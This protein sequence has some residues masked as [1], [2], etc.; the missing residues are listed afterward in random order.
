MK[1]CNSQVPVNNLCV[2]NMPAIKSYFS[3]L[4]AV[5]LYL[6]LPLLFAGSEHIQAQQITFNKTFGNSAYNQGV[7]TFQ[8]ADSGYVVVGNSA[9]FAGTTA[10]YL[11]WID[12]QGNLL[13]DRMISRPFLLKVNGA[14]MHDSL[15]YLTGFAYNQG[16]YDFM[17]LKIDLA[18]N[19]LLEKYWGT[20][21]W[22]FANDLVVDNSKQIYLAGESTDTVYGEMNGVVICLDSN[23]VLIWEKS[24]GGPGY[25]A[26]FAID[27]GFGQTLVMAG[28]SAGVSTPG[29]SAFYLASTDL[30][31]N[32]LWERVLNAPGTNVAYDIQPDIQGGYILCG[33]TSSPSSVLGQ[34]ALLFKTDTTGNLLWQTPFGMQ[35]NDA[36]HAVLQLPDST[37]RMAGY[38]AGEFSYGMNDFYFQNATKFGNWGGQAAGYIT[39]GGTKDDWAVH[40][41]RTL[42]GGFLLTGTTN[43]F[44]YGLSNIFLLKLGDSAQFSPYGGHQTAMS[45]P[46]HHIMKRFEVYPNPAK[47]DLLITGRGTGNSPL[48]CYLVDIQ[49]RVVK[50]FDPNLFTE[51]SVKLQ[52]GDLPEGI[53]FLKIGEEAFRII[54]VR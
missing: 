48:H 34:E 39:I 31:G 38:N 47:D 54:K 24:F 50:T 42:D 52:I 21:G 37:Y 11:A 15:L 1:Q 17:L 36:F 28:T 44:G 29:D 27:T 6:V 9:G 41:I 4:P 49:G 7:A 3:K 22:N 13:S 14:E 19:V 18:G 26:F 25:D 23:G 30:Q 45:E 43:S 53:Y 2:H 40:M 10:P 8:L 46:D 16:S 51:S 33:E 32:I 20:Q 5:L 12:M 35:S